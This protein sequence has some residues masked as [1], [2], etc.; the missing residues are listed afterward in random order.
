L[1]FLI[2]SGIPFLFFYLKNRDENKGFLSSLE[3]SLRSDNLLMSWT[4][5]ISIIATVLTGGFTSYVF[6]L[7]ILILFLLDKQERKETGTSSAP[8][9]KF[10]FFKLL[11]L[12]VIFFIVV[13]TRS[14][15]EDV[16]KIAYYGDYYFYA[17]V[18]LSVAFNGI[19]SLNLGEA[20]SGV[21]SI[22]P[23]HYFELYTSGLLARASGL[24]VLLIYQY[25]ALS[26]AFA[27]ISFASLEFL[28][29]KKVNKLWVVIPLLL[30]F[31]TPVTPL[32]AT[33]FREMDL[34]THSTKIA[35]VILFLACAIKGFLE[36]NIRH[37]LLF[38]TLLGLT[39]PTTA[40][41]ILGGAGSL[42]VLFFLFSTRWLDLSKKDLVFLGVLLFALIAN[43]L[44]LNHFSSSSIHADTSGELSAG[45]FLHTFGFLTTTFGGMA[46]TRYLPY[47]LILLFLWKV[48]KSNL[49]VLFFL[50]LFL[51]SI[52]VSA[53]FYPKTDSEQ[54]VTNIVFP[55]LFTVSLF[56]A[57]YIQSA[58]IK[59]LGLLL[60]IAYGIGYLKFRDEV[61][62]LDNG[63]VEILKEVK[64]AGGMFV[65]SY[66]SSETVFHR[67][68]SNTDIDNYGKEIMN[69]TNKITVSMTD[70]RPLLD[71]PELTA[72]MK[73]RLS[74]DFMLNFLKNNPGTKLADF[75]AVNFSC[76]FAN[77]ATP[78]SFLE[79]KNFIPRK[80]EANT[81][82]GHGLETLTF[83]ARQN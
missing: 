64:N 50:G 58:R 32:H 57:G 78:L 13:L 8:D 73:A 28:A 63:Y 67:Y 55:F 29:T 68:F 60:L 42:L 31:L 48:V 80:I 65:G 6:V 45:G 53:F 49:L 9:I 82:F 44:F 27:V 11:L 17:K 35:F 4:L 54:I 70:V 12:P 41:G 22:T 5:F 34:L 77:D 7:G 56:L 62:V 76:V 25:V 15:F 52:A 10:L 30:L 79:E 74:N 24:P 38:M 66:K 36:K 1:S 3:A 59:T 39:Y 18:A 16:S 23:Y 2:L 37:F 20:F 83:Y 14:G 51:A 81:G 33:Y 43:L 19:E 72:E 69:F 61:L 71:N 47:V 75:V 21:Q 46:L 26:L 40:F